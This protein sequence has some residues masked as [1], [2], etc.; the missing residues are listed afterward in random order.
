M[1]RKR[2]PQIPKVLHLEPIKYPATSYRLYISGRQ[3]NK[4]EYWA[5]NIMRLYDDGNRRYY[6]TIE[7]KDELEAMMRFQKLWVGLPKKEQEDD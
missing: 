3:A 4:L 7:A 1:A 5:F 2:K 6:L